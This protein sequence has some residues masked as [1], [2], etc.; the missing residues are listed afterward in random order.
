M[1]KDSYDVTRK[2]NTLRESALKEKPSSL[3]GTNYGYT[4]YGNQ[5]I[6]IG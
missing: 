3:I 4:K 1:I 6:D 5:N 2:L